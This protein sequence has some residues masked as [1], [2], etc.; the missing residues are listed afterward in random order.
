MGE[1]TCSVSVGFMHRITEKVIK[2]V[3]AGRLYRRLWQKG[4][5]LIFWQVNHG[6]RQEIT[7]GFFFRR[8]DPKEVTAKAKSLT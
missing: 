8:W 6:S 1:L 3:H 4:S 2:T 7:C 5:S